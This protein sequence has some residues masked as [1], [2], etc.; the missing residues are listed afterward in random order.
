MIKD[1]IDAT[2]KADAIIKTQQETTQPP[3]T[4]RQKN[5]IIMDVMAMELYGTNEWQFWQKYQVE[6]V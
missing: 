6:R 1:A 4:Q 2:E 5:L 3:E